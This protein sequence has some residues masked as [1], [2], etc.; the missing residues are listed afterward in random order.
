MSKEKFMSR[1]ILIVDDELNIRKTIAMI[2]R[3][4]GWETETAENGAIALALLEREEF[5]VIFLDLGMS[6]RDGMEVLADIRIKRPEQAVV[7]LTGQ[8]TI[9]RALEATRLGA[10]DFLEKDCGKERILLTSKNALD[11]STLARENRK[12]RQRAGEQPEFLGTSPAAMGILRQIAKVAPTNARGLSLGESGTGK[13]LIAQAVHERKQARFDSVHMVWTAGVFLNLVLNWWVLFSWRGHEVWSFTLFLSLIVW[14]VA[15]YMPVVFLYPT[16]KPPRES[17]AVVFSSNRQWFL[18]GF[19]FFAA[20]DIWVT[21]LRGGL[22]DPPIYLPF[23]GHYFLLWVAGV[24]VDAPRYQK[25]LAW[26]TLLSLAAWSL[27]V[28]RFIA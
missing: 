15:L 14:A 17:W 13:E 28:R 23:V 6:E 9:E 12:L 7:I 19:A 26:Y 22:F 16:H 3:N 1:R 21:A 10:F 5:D 27:V 24:F 20:A 18:G 11:F 25:F 8:G 4:A 2:H